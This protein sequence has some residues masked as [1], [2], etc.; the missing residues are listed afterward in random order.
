MNII[1][2]INAKKTQ[3]TKWK[4]KP[5]LPQS[6]SSNQN[7]LPQKPSRYLSHSKK[8]KRKSLSL[9]SPSPR[10]MAVVRRKMGLARRKKFAK[11]PAKRVKVAKR[12]AR[13]VKTAVRM[14]KK[15]PLRWS[16][17]IPRKMTLLT[18]KGRSSQL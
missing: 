8:T 15:F 3:H 11:R 17:S 10:R 6:Q 16:L 4:P 5:Q 1:K 18:K 13:R 9:R 7:Q 12:P 2:T 14:P